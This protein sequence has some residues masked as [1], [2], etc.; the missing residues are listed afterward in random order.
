MDI[1]LAAV[2]LHGDE[3]AHV[4]AEVARLG[5]GSSDTGRGDLERV[6]L[7]AHHVGVVEHPVDLAGRLGDLVEGDPA[8]L[9]DGDAQD[10]TLAGR[11]DVD[12]LDV[13][14]QGT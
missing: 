7:L 2:V 13:E 12:G 5:E 8:V 3:A 14:T 10:P 4:A 1:D 11:R 6:G 9:V